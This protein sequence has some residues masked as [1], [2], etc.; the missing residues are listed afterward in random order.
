[1][2]I[3]P[4][5][6]GSHTLYVPALSETYHSLHGAVQ[7]SQH[8]F[9]QNGLLHWLQ[10]H[11]AS[12][13]TVLEVGLGTGLNALLT[14]LMAEQTA[15]TVQ[16]TALEPFPIP[17][18]CVAGLNYSRRLADSGH[19]PLDALQAVFETIHSQ[20]EGVTNALSSYFAL[21]KLHTSV[22]DFASPP[23]AFDLVY[24][25]AFAPSK[26]PSMW[27]LETLS[28]VVQ[29]IRP[30]G[31]LVTYCVQGQFRRHLKQLGLAVTTLPGPP[32]KKE[33]TRAVCV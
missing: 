4:T 32:G 31:L 30:G 28:T 3:I 2:Q 1:M 17:L 7:E 14:Y 23:V 13:V 6:D 5:R 24:F 8:V 9:I 22:A 10:Q 19:M 18:A 11:S 21:Q 16:Y 20:P 33:M 27:T 12:S 29:L 25:D 26:Q 15:T